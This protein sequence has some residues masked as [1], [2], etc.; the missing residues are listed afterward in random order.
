MIFRWCNAVG[1]R[2]GLVLGWVVAVCLT[3]A[4]GGELVLRY[5]SPAARWRE[6]LPLGN[7]HLGITVSGGVCHERLQLSENSIYSG[8]WG[9]LT[10]DPLEAEYIKRQRELAV[11]GDLDAAV[12]LTFEEFKESWKGEKP[13]P[14]ELKGFKRVSKPARRPIEQTLGNLDLFFPSHHEVVED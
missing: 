1:W 5:D 4:T 14:V 11:G 8:G 3:E 9:T 13:E 2:Q 12:A 6:S 10:V 7:G